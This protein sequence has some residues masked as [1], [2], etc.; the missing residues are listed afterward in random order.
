MIIIAEKQL[1]IVVYEYKAQQIDELD[2][3]VNDIIEVQ[4]ITVLIDLKWGRPSMIV[5]NEASGRWMESRK[6]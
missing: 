2:L 5:D 1:H 3:E 4:S 6:E